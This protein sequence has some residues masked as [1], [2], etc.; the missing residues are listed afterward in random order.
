MNS[1]M[2]N[3][4]FFATMVAAALLCATAWAEEPVRYDDWFEDATLRLDYIFSGD[5]E[6]Q[7]ICFVQAYS[8]DGWAGRR[9]RLEKPQYTANGQVSLSD[10]E[11]GATLY[12]NS[13]ST[14]F[15]EWTSQTEE[16]RQVTK[17]F[18]ECFNVPMPKKP[19]DVRIFLTDEHNRMSAE[20]RHR[21]DP[22]D[23]L[24]QRQTAGKWEV[25][26]IWNPGDPAERIDIAFIAEGYTAEEMEKFFADA[27]RCAGYF[28]E[29]EPFASK[30]GQLH[31]VA[32]GVQSRD[33]GVSVPHDGVWK[34]TELSCHYD[35]FYSER[36][37]TSTNLRRAYD[38]LAGVPFEHVVVLINTPSYGGGGMYNNITFASSDNVATPIV[39]V[40]EFGH[41]FAG[42]AD[43]YAYD[44]YLPMYFPDTEP[45]EPNIT[46]LKDFDSKWA[47]LYGS[48][49]VSELDEVEKTQDVR[50]TWG[51]LTEEQ[52]ESLTKKIGLYEGAGNTSKGVYRPV[53]ECRMRMNECEDFCPVCTRAIIS[54][55]DYYTGR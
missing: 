27:E 28:L 22:K 13:F 35:T 12:C 21:I 2:K 48:R 4:R 26:D 44:E 36:Y 41:A 51:S 43:E 10:P 40:H 18:E 31:F 38:A 42:L 1:H 25:R 19:V 33:S 20:L 6:S 17:G 47:D 11:T 37:L 34:D 45:W 52:K 55:I 3:P 54:T 39:L 32:V 23:I 9:T 8:S 49:K 16:A 15:Q 53:Q 24:I 5:F 30:A 46:T 29:H 14:L 7:S 50:R